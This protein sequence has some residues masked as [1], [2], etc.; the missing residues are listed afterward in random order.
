MA[1]FRTEA[2]ALG[3]VR[4]PADALWGAATQRALEN[5][6][7]S[8]RRFPRPFIGMLGLLKATAA[9]VNGALG[10][11]DAAH[12]GSIAA[13]A[14]A[15]AEGKHDAAFP[16]DI[17]Q[18]GSGTSVNMNANEVIAS[19]ANLALGGE[20]GRFSPIHPNDHVNRCQSSNDVIPSVIHLA[21][22][23][24]IEQ[25][26]IPALETLRAACAL[27]AKA[28]DRIL[29]IGR[30][31]LMDAMPVRLGQ[32]FAG[33]ARQAE[34][35][36]ERLRRCLPA[37]AELA[38]GGTAVGTGA[39]AHPDFAPLV[40]E[41]LSSE[42]LLDFR[43]ASDHFEALSS[44]SAC[45]ESSGALTACATSL[46]R[47]A[48]DI[49]LLASG[50]RLGI[51]EIRLPAL[52]PGSSIMPGKV[53]PVIP[54]VVCQVGGQVIAN[55]TA[56]AIAGQSGHLELS[57]MLPLIASNLL[58]SIAILAAAARTFAERC[59][60]GIEACEETCNERIE[61]SLALATALVPKLGYDQAAA[62]AKEAAAT[63]KTVREVALAQAVASEEE[64]DELLD[65]DRLTRGS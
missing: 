23:T 43:P 21:A 12:A 35:G 33:F 2:D 50:P 26:L 11:I 54:E 39:G 44:R 62:I 28:F 7:I 25:T 31:H 55:G 4:V 15:V 59:I 20:L 36:I 37:L 51:G 13:A 47:I 14:Y 34:K 30:T 8:T 22:A 16:L 52:Q 45:V 5:F 63:G 48:D 10:L 41:K 18:T 58:E 17:F 49:R 19:L 57:T 46:V 65:V 53:N 64:L 3:E 27:K 56:V 9:T 29:K 40:C 60:A 42:L 1:S 38:L 24:E 32:E 61:R 6:S